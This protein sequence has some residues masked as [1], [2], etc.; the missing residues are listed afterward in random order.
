MI[1]HIIHNESDLAARRDNNG[2]VLEAEGGERSETFA[3]KEDAVKAGQD[4]GREREHR[5]Q[6]SQLIV[7]RQDGSIEIEWSYG[8]RPQRT[9]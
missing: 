8:C 5:G 7:H 6:D 4:R 1:M 2:W 9:G 3:T